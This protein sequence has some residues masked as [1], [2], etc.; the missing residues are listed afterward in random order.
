[1]VI[2]IIPI[3]SVGQ[4]LLSTQL[5]ILTQE[6]IEGSPLDE[7]AGCVLG[8][9]MH[10]VSLLIHML[11][12]LFTTYILASVIDGIATRIGSKTSSTD[13]TST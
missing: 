5:P 8:V 4:L 11:I 2:F 1:M 3:F 12:W 6:C 10:W 9:T 7:S 13:T